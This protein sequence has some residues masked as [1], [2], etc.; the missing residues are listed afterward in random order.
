MKTKNVFA[1]IGICALISGNQMLAQSEP[2][3]V[4][5]ATLP[6]QDTLPSEAL[7]NA[8]L[9]EVMARQS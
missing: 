1:A 5:G 8:S 6:V 7:R 4:S 2:D 3:A 9:S